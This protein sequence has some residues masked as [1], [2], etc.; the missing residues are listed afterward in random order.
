MA[1]FFNVE[2]G[3]LR[4][5]DLYTDVPDASAPSLDDVTGATL[6]PR[7]SA[8]PA[9]RAPAWTIPPTMTAVDAKREHDRL[10]AEWIADPQHV[11]GDERHRE[12]AQAVAHYLALGELAAGRD[13][14]DGAEVLGEVFANGQI[15]APGADAL[16]PAPRP[17]LPEGH[18]W[19]ESALRA[20]ETEAH[21]MGM[22]SHF[23]MTV[24]DELATMIEQEG[25]RRA[26]WGCEDGL[27][28]LTRWY[29]TERAA[30]VVANAQW[31][32]AAKIRQQEKAEGDEARA[33]SM[34]RVAGMHRRWGKSEP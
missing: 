10:R 25:H 11:L 23:V 34:E 6:P 7:P 12:H 28:E 24:T 16:S 29:G 4:D 26:G 15:R 18:A 8:A 13:P 17:Q 21:A 20:A 30:R 31:T 19:D 14:A 1:P 22:P 5:P 9:P 3:E 32:L 2:T 33:A 27:A